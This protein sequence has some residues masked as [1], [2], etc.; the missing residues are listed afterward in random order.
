MIEVKLIF[1]RL[2]K[3]YPEL[4]VAEEELP[5]LVF[6]AKQTSI[7]AESVKQQQKDSIQGW[8]RLIFKD[9]FGIDL[10]LHD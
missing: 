8:E 2:L 6:K 1:E 4:Y 10:I 9:F 5:D 7:E 3:L